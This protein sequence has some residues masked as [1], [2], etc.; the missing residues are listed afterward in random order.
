MSAKKGLNLSELGKSL[1]KID[2]QLVTILAKRMCVAVEVARCKMKNNDQPIL[3]K[4]IER[5]R[6]VQWMAW[7]RACG[8]DPEFARTVFNIVLSESCRIQIQTKEK[9]LKK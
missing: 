1:A 2:E 4:K 7:A 5:Q 8:M 9:E 6:R 3:R